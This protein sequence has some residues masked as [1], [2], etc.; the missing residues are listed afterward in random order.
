MQYHD[1]VHHNAF[2]ISYDELNL[3]SNTSDSFI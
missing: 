2:K 1:D 3:S